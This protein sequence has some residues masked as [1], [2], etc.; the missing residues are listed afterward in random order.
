MNEEKKESTVWDREESKIQFFAV[1]PY[2]P[3]LL[4]FLAHSCCLP[5]PRLL[6]IQLAFWLAYCNIMYHWGSYTQCTFAAAVGRM[7]SHK[8]ILLCA[9]WICVLFIV[10]SM[11]K[12]NSIQISN[13]RI[14]VICSPFRFRF[15]MWIKF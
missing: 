14:W 1:A 7:K 3:L 9:A 8:N 5:F 12:K 15:W 6:Y 11:I 2:A 10:W 4:F 13:H